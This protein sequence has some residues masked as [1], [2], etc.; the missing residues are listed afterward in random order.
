MP[1][2]RRNLPNVASRDVTSPLYADLY[3]L[4]DWAVW[5]Q[6]HHSFVVDALQQH[7]VAT[8]WRHWLDLGPVQVESTSLHEVSIDRAHDPEPRQP[9]SE[10]PFVHL[11]S[12]PIKIVLNKRMH[13]ATAYYSVNGRSSSVPTD[14]TFLCGIEFAHITLNQRSSRPNTL[15]V[16]RMTYKKHAPPVLLR[17]L[18][19]Y[20]LDGKF[21]ATLRTQLNLLGVPNPQVE[22]ASGN[23]PH[24]FGIYIGPKEYYGGI[25]MPLDYAPTLLSLLMPKLR[26]VAALMDDDNIYRM[27]RLLEFW[28]PQ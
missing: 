7:H 11:P 12:P 23:H 4:Q 2:R 3:Q 20:L 17:W 28:R 6:R 13:T 9:P 16:E 18:N 8:V 24:G 27:D 14:P 22:L 26:L 21:D 15:H 25:G 1:I 19:R 10:L 5:E